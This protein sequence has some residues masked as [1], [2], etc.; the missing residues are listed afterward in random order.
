MLRALLRLILVVAILVG[1]AGFLLGWWGGHRMI[2]GDAGT[3]V[4]TAGHVDAER[5]K[6][7]GAKAGEKTAELANRAGDVFNDGALTAKIK[8]KMALDDL[9]QA[10]SIDVSTKGGVVT[11]SG[12]V[13]SA[14]EHDRA[15]QLARET[16]GV[17]RVV[18]HLASR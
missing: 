6:E 10:R 13:R 9:V 8:S 5:A 3:T 15:V 7:V 14:A 1:A 16:S 2:G 4:G 18:D 11:L 12:T 17:S